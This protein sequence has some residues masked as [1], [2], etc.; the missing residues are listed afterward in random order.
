MLK[1]GWFQ[2]VVGSAITSFV[3]LA[4]VAGTGRLAFAAEPGDGAITP[5]ATGN[6]GFQNALQR[7]L[8]ARRWAY[9]VPRVVP[10]LPSTAHLRA[11]QPSG[12]ATLRQPI[13]FKP[14]ALVSD[15]W[16]GG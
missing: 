14:L 1:T 11:F 4:V 8:T 7:I 10:P 13:R 3:L 9:V 6:L 2:G 12:V 5:G 15:N 16:L